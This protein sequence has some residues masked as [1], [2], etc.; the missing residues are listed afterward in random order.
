MLFLQK[1]QAENAPA[2]VG[3][4][5]T[6]MAYNLGIAT[7]NWENVPYSQAD[8]KNFTPDYDTQEQ[9]YATIQKLLDEAITE[10]AK[11]TGTKPAAD[12]LIYNGDTAK[13]TRLAYSLKARYAMHLSNKNPQQAATGRDYCL[14]K[15]DEK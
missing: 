6:L 1:G 11:N 13:W 5:K 4:A 2:Y 12:D 8:Q 14:A 9:I 7:V 15:W 3:I 10:L